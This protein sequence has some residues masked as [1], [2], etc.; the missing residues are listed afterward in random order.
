MWIKTFCLPWTYR[1]Q[2]TDHMSPSSRKIVLL[3]L[4]TAGAGD[5][6]CLPDVNWCP[7]RPD[8][9]GYIPCK[10][11]GRVT[12]LQIS[13]A[14]IFLIRLDQVGKL[15]THFPRTAACASWTSPWYKVWIFQRAHLTTTVE[16]FYPQFQTNKVARRHK[17]GA[18]QAD[19]YR[20]YWQCLILSHCWLPELL[21]KSAGTWLWPLQTYLKRC[22]IPT[23]FDIE[24][25]HLNN[26]QK[27]WVNWDCVV[28]PK[29]IQSDVYSTD[30]NLQLF[31]ILFS[32]LQKGNLTCM[33]R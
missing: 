30:N 16:D 15:R 28:Q 27:V 17:D 24:A 33:S 29:S 13:G 7:E 8:I 2:F 20:A 11:L 31:Y 19:R 3:F 12:I 32:R 5:N 10:V 18:S 23:N 14:H 26:T 22:S 9:F 1:I 21:V 4:S 25:L 6:I